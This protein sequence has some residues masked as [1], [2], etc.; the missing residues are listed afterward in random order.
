MSTVSQCQYTKEYARYSYRQVADRYDEIIQ[1]LIYKQ[2]QKRFNKKGNSFVVVIA[3]AVLCCCLWGCW[4]G[5]YFMQLPDKKTTTT[6]NEFSESVDT[7]L[8]GTTFSGTF[9]TF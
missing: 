8:P 6:R 5:N 2:N 9:M 3:V 7:V 1:K 4:G